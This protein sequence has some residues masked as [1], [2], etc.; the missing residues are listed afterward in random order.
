MV[1]TSM[2]VA[3][4]GVSAHGFMVVLG[5]HHPEFAHAH[6]PVIALSMTTA[7]SVDSGYIVF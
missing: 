1:S 3:P 4:W 7:M 6:D 5:Q 2:F